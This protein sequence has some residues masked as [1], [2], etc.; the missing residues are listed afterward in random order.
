MVDEAQRAGLKVI[1]HAHG[2]EGAAAAVR[3]GVHAIEHGT[4]VS[5]ETLRLM[6]DKGV[7]PDPTLT[8]TMDLVDPEGDYDNPILQIRGRAMLPV[9]RE[10]V[11]K[12]WRM[13]VKIIAGTDTGYA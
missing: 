13:G 12:A 4:Y 1:S 5:D 7:Y 8:A 3:A 10:M 9:A 11:G 2:D 6:K